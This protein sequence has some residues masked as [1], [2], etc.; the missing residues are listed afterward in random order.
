MP[1]TEATRRALRGLVER[2]AARH[3]IVMLDAYQTVQLKEQ[4]QGFLQ[5]HKG[6]DE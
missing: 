5:K 1:D 2:V 3:A 4:I 6:G